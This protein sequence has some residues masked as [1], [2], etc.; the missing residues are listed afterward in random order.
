MR[1]W[2]VRGRVILAIVAALLAIGAGEISRRLPELGAGGVLH[3]A[4]RHVAQPAPTSCLETTFAGD[5]VTLKGWTCRSSAPRIG[6]LIYLHGI[7]DNR[8]S[9]VGAIQRFTA[10]GFDVIAY[11]SRAHGE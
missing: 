1:T 6:T 10:R 9:A 7:A 4:R 2:R 11:D 5:G 3:P 8:A